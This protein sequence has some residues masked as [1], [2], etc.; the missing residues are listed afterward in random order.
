MTIEI[1]Q[2]GSDF[3]NLK[4]EWNTHLIKIASHVP[5]LRHEYL[6]SWW[7]TLGGGEWE[8]GELLILTSR[9]QSN[10]LQGIAPFFL[11]NQRIMFLGS[12]QIS[13]YLDLIAGPD[14]LVGFINEIFEFLQSAE[15]PA[16]QVLDLFNLLENSPTIPLLHKAAESNGWFI[17]EEVLGPAPFLK[18]PGSWEDYRNQLD[19]RYRHEIE[20]KNRRAENYFLPVSWYIVED[21][22]LLDQELESFL[23]LMAHNPEKGSFLTGRMISQLKSSAREAFLAGWLQLAFLTVGDI[24]AAG[25]L[26]FDYDGK[27]WVYNSGI[28]PMFEN[29]SPGWVLLSKIIQWSIEAGKTELDFMRGDETY[30]YN[31]GGIDKQVLRI[32]VSRK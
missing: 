16:W 23:E 3:L 10:L 17:K 21:E 28:N 8:Q 5:F 30:K 24:K 26:N 32:Q 14:A 2:S 6:T 11:D 27:I 9:D 25:Y 18:L 19:D 12:H 20:R 4:K 7:S 1:I 31:F 13:D 15:S 29:I 22:K